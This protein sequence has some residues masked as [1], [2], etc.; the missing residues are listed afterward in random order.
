MGNI[1]PTTE[2]ILLS[3][4][5]YSFSVESLGFKMSAVAKTGSV[6]TCK[7]YLK[8][9]GKTTFT[10]T[11]EG[12]QEIKALGADIVS[13]QFTVDVSTSTKESFRLE[14]EFQVIDSYYYKCVVYLVKLS[15]NPVKVKCVLRGLKTNPDTSIFA[16]SRNYGERVNI[17]EMTATKNSNI[18]PLILELTLLQIAH[19]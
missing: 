13:P 15:G 7:T 11:I 16:I 12:L 19:E 3:K 17:S 10:W 18:G 5:L 14:I 8:E 1:P 2:W 4:K 6:Q 9:I